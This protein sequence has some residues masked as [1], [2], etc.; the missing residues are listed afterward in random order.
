MPE[1]GADMQTAIGNLAA[2]LREH[3]E[4]AEGW[5]LLGRTYKAT[6]QYADARDAF[7]HALEAAPGDT[8]LAREFAAIEAPLDAAR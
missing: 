7:R 8:E 2:K 4:D 6:Q 5:A 1:H 3:P